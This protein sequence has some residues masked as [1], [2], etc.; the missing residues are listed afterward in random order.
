MLQ[1]KGGREP[2]R[3]VMTPNNLQSKMDEFAEHVRK[4]VEDWGSPPPNGYWKP[5]LFVQVG[6]G[7]E[8]AFA[9]L[10]SL[11]TNSGFEIRRAKQ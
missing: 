2:S 5:M 7:G 11:L 6:P 8:S 4:H 3:T 9:E 10:Q 1:E